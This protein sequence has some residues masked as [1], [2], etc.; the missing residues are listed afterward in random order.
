MRAVLRALVAVAIAGCALNAD[1]Q[2]LQRFGIGGDGEP[3]SVLQRVRAGEFNER[4]NANI[5]GLDEQEQRAQAE[6]NARQ[7]S[8][9]QAPSPDVY[10]LLDVMFNAPSAAK[11]N[12][13]TIP[14]PNMD[15]P[16]RS[17]AARI[18][19]VQAPPAG[20]R[21]DLRMDIQNAEDIDARQVN[22]GEILLSLGLINAL[23]NR[24]AE[25]PDQQ[26]T[27]EYAFI[28][29]H[30]YAHVLMCHYNRPLAQER[31]R[32][33]FRS[34]STIGL[35]LA[36]LTNS[37]MTR[38]ASG[39]VVET[40]EDAGGDMLKLLAATT[41]LS[42]FNS[43]IVNPAWGR[44]QER[45]ADR[46]AVELLREAPGLDAAAAPGLVAD[47]FNAD[48]TAN[49]RFRQIAEAVPREALGALILSLND[50]DSGQSL[51][52]RLQAVALRAGL[53]AFLQWR[54][55]QRRHFH[56]NA[57]RRSARLAEMDQFLSQ[58]AVVGGAVAA[59][60]FDDGDDFAAR[61]G[62]AL[63]AG[64]STDLIAPDLA[65]Q[66]LEA[67]MAGDFT[68]GCAHAA[69][70]LR[71]G[72]NLVEALM[73]SGECE[74]HRENKAGAARHFN[75]ALRQERAIPDNF[76]IVSG[77]W[78]QFD[79][80]ARAEEALA[81]GGRRF[82]PD[83]FYVDRIN[84]AGEFNDLTAVAAITTECQSSQ[85]PEVKEHCTRRQAEL[86]NAAAE[87]AQQA[88]AQQ[89][90]GAGNP[91]TSLLRGGQNALGRLTGG[92]SQEPNPDAAQS[93][94]GQAQNPPQPPEGG[95]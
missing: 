52:S 42:E 40:D 32:Q 23:R 30:E 75:A 2:I 27:N 41:L 83:R 55:N 87:E 28:I 38:N 24:S 44:G 57:E 59:G 29:A 14:M 63:R 62:A 46:L 33:A 50:Q 79:E 95:P 91:L 13:Q 48:R 1:A 45:D 85:I 61:Q 19:A 4:C 60:V 65:Q 16:L 21:V 47:L 93:Q 7:Q 17:I 20:V 72:P 68:A 73:V 74:L 36:V 34:M 9:Q 71:A 69:Q 10:N 88:N 5:A 89:Q 58:N 94:E 92:G 66:A 86:I 67:M 3:E 18:M 51:Q 49:E 35:L 26:I 84:I 77:I 70:A 43:S 90:G 11:N 37:T 53:Q 15:V 22:T 64:Y 8:G 12:V 80:R 6:Q 78:A 76:K 82:G 54:I 39:V 25:V 56:E 81:A 31:N